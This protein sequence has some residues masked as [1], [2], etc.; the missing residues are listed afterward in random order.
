MVGEALAFLNVDFLVVFPVVREH[1]LCGFISSKFVKTCFMG[2][3][4]I[5]FIISY[6]SEKNV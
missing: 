4:T 1:T 3:H 5:N 2:K 6:A